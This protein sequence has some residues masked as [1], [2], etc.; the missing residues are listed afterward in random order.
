VEERMV[1]KNQRWETV[2]MSR[3]KHR[4]ARPRQRWRT[5]GC[6]V[7]EATHQRIRGVK[8]RV[9]WLFAS[10]HGTGQFFRNDGKEAKTTL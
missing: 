1:E 7:R 10:V 9:W 2:S 4:H 8:G 6:Q 5:G 3:K